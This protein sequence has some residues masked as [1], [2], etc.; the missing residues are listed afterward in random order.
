M[1]E[2]RTAIE[3]MSCGHC[4]AAVHQALK[5]VPGI[6]VRSVVVG[7]AVFG[8]ESRQAAE[9]AVEAIREAGFE[10]RVVDAPS[11]AAGGARG[12]SQGD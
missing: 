2:V 8:T 12:A 11:G 9:A 10:A 1:I 3:G 6:E 7:E 4:V 5:G